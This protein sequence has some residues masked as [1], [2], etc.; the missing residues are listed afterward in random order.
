MP[1]VASGDFTSRK[2]PD[3]SPERSVKLN[4]LNRSTHQN[5][6]PERRQ[7]LNVALSVLRKEPIQARLGG[8][9]EREL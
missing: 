2:D 8:D 1:D 5:L 4:A 9:L 6:S 7:L 3:L